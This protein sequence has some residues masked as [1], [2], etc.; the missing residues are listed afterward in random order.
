MMPPSPHFPQTKNVWVQ[1]KKISRYLG[2]VTL[3][4]ETYL[5]EGLGDEEA[6]CHL[7]RLPRFIN[8]D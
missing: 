6:F 3:R 1:Q 5:P 7:P 2:Q 4:L 8:K